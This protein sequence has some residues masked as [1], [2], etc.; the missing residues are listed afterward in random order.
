MKYIKYIRYVLYMVFMRMKGFK[1]WFIL[2]FKGEEA[3][4]RYGQE[5]FKKWTDFTIN[6]IGMKFD[7]KG[8]E[9]IPD[10]TV[11]FMGNHQSI[12]DIPTMRVATERTLDFVAKK[13][14]A[15]AP[16]IGYWVTKVKSVT[17]D[18]ENVREGMKSINTAVKN[19]KDGYNFVIFPEGTRSKDGNIQ[20]FKKGAIK[21]ATK[22]K[23]PIIPVAIKGTSAC[24]E[25]NKDFLP[26]VVKVTFGEPIYTKD[27]SKDEEKEL[28]SKVEEKVRNLYAKL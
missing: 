3:A 26:G 19:V 13:E 22:S 25:D 20:E 18:R 7:V 5:V 16:L 24:F 23:A 27:L 10:E 2:K 28:M 6:I 17:I 11:I 15:D 21:I 8:R 9:N 1:R 4:W 14:I 12:L